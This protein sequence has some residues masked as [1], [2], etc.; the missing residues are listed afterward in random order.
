[1]PLAF[2]LFLVV[3]IV[4]G[5][6]EG[7]FSLF[8]I[9]EVLSTVIGALYT[10]LVVVLVR[11][12]RAGRRELSAG[13]L[14]RA[15]LPMLG[16]LVLEAIVYG[17]GVF[18]GSLLLLVPGL[19]LATIWAVASPV[20]VIERRPVFDALGRSRRLV[21][22]NG[23]RVFGTVIVTGVVILAIYL[24]FR[25]LAIAIADGPI[26]LA[27]FNALASTVGAP[28]G[29]LLVS[30]LYFRLLAIHDEPAAPEPAVAASVPQ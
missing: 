26:F 7:D 11:D 24:S 1:M 30:V 22:G 5:P 20:I 16:T 18:F 12:V 8:W 15:V 28:F 27:V 19:Y 17:L 2:W 29:G 13:D 3:A 14:G 10:G 4:N 25:A 21:K 23:W 9:G 6:T